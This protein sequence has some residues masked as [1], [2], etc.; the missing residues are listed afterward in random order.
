VLIH[1]PSGCATGA[2][3]KRR[4]VHSILLRRDVKR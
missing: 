2:Q 4:L 1:I 3:R